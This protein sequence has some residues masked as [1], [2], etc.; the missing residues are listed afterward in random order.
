FSGGQRQRIAIARA[1]A[2]SP[3][4]IVC[5]E[6]VSALDVSVQAQIL[7][8]LR[9]LQKQLGVAFLFIA[10][11]IAVVEYVSHRIG[12]MYL[13]EIVEMGPKDTLLT[14]PQHPY[15]QALLSAVPVPDPSSAVPRIVLSGD[16]P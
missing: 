6:A 7:N 5:D 13:G 1:L 9:R 16:L 14:A 8:L 11:D 4:L 3:S 15:T 10:H 12:V 2:L